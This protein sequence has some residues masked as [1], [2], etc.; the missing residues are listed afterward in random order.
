MWLVG[1]P[2]CSLHRMLDWADWLGHLKGSLAPVSS[3]TLASFNFES[4]IH[5][6]L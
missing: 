4:A 1:S 6:L 5:D 3:M 2:N